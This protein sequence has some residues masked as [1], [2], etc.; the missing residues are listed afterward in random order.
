MKCKF[1]N[2]EIDLLGSLEKQCCSWCEQEQPFYHHTCWICESPLQFDDGV[3]LCDCGKEYISESARKEI[4]QMYSE[5]LE[6][7][8]ERMAYDCSGKN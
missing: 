4:T 8:A 2:Q 3:A 7:C 6:G 1:C 5:Y